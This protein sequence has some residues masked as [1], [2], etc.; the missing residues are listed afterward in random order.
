MTD[1]STIAEARSG[2]PRLLIKSIPAADPSTLP[3]ANLIQ[4]I[5]L[6]L[7]ALGCPTLDVNYTTEFEEMDALLAH[8]RE[9]NLLLANYL[10]PADNRTQTFRYDYLQQPPLAKL[11]AP[12]L[13]L[14]RYGL[15]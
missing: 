13:A 6:K 9:I 11:P 4:H 7:A 10:C 2:A 5:N 12:T 8:Q 3:N 1:L 15:A 14:D